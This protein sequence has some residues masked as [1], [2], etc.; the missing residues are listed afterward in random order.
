MFS[1]VK[2]CRNVTLNAEGF[3]TLDIPRHFARISLHFRFMF[4]LAFHVPF[5]L[6]SFPLM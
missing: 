5:M 2:T 3:F 4:I 6:H 1:R